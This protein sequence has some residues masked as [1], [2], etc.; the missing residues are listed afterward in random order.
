MRG[1]LFLLTASLLIQ[2]SASAASHVGLATAAVPQKDRLEGRWSGTAE[3]PVGGKQDAFVT[4]KKEGDGYS[5]KISGLRP[6]MEAALKD[7]K[8]LK[9]P[10]RA[11]PQTVAP[12]QTVRVK[13]EPRAAPRP[14]A[15]LPE[16]KAQTRA[17]PDRATAEKMR[18][19][20]MAVEAT[21]RVLR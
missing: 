1:A 18:R 6:G 21:L 20:Q 14:S 4:F 10:A 9:S 17:H 3:G 15:P 13:V 16:L 11:K 2:G 19:G 12:V 8:P 7:V 5:G